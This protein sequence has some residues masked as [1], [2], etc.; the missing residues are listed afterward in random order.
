MP[1]EVSNTRKNSRKFIRQVYRRPDGIETAI[2]QMEP[3]IVEMQPPQVGVSMQV[4]YLSQSAMTMHGA[5]VSSQ[6]TATAS[7]S[8]QDQPTQPVASIPASQGI[9]P[10]QAR[11]RPKP[12]PAV[13]RNASLPSF[14][15]TSSE[16]FWLCVGCASYPQ[17]QETQGCSCATERKDH[18]LL[19]KLEVNDGHFS[20]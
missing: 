5:S 12:P 19:H 11:A 13:S 1:K 20:T 10:T 15:I 2:A 4:A 9:R 7:S 3:D 8:T 18:A 14:S 16:S 17:G 6:A